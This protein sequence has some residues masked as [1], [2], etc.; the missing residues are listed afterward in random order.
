MKR[1]ISLL[2][3]FT[4]LSSGLA[5]QSNFSKQDTLRGSITPERV[6][7]DLL[8]YNLDFKVSP[9]LKNIEGSNII[10][11]E[12]LSQKQL[13]QIDLQPPM[14]ITSS[15]GCGLKIITLFFA[16]LDLSGLTLSSESGLPPGHPVIDLC[17][18][19]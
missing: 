7:W 17:N 19:L 2:L 3:I 8:H 10:R 15:S 9:S 16:G 4:T 14:E 11:Y 6:W 12:V 5:Q 18:L 1:C 13:M